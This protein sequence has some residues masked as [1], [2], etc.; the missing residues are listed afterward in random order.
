MIVVMGVSG[1]GKTTVG[2]RLAVLLNIPFYDADDFH[3]LTSIEKMK[4][5][6][7]LTNLDRYPWLQLLSE[8][9]ERWNNEGGAVLACSALKEEYRVILS[10]RTTVDW[11]Y[12]A[13]SFETIHDRMKKRDHYMKP[14]MLQSQFDTLEIP[15]YGIHVDVSQSVEETVSKIITLFEANE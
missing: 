4:S 3:P 10:A 15:S 1:C 12:L 13:A 2:K 7:P 8:K 5:G 14:E 6:T 9:M 11:V